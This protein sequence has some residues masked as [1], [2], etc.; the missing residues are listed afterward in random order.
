VAALVGFESPYT[1][2]R[3]VVALMAG[4]GDT[5]ESAVA[6]IRDSEQSAFVQG[7]LSILTTGKVTSYR[8]A[9]IYTVGHL[10]FWL[11]PSYILRDQAY[12]VVLIMLFGSGL[13]GTAL[14]WLMRRRGYS[15]LT[16]S[17]PPAPHAH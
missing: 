10:P 8:V 5:L 1:S 3:S 11:Y 2:H 4:S 12:S 15:R 9:Q 16:P 6:T 13:C 14:F 17:E 7:D